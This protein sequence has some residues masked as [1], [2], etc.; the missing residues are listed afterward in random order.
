MKRIAFAFA[1]TALL[2]FPLGAQETQREKKD[3]NP[4]R[5]LVVAC[6]GPF[7][8]RATHAEMV[9]TF[10]AANVTYGDVPGPEGS[11]EQATILFADDP[12]KRV[13]IQWHDAKKRARPLA[14]TIGNAEAN[15]QWT[16]PYGVKLGTG[17]AE[18]QKI[19]GK[20]FEVSGFEW[21]LGGFANLQNTKFEKVSGGCTLSLR[22]AP[23]KAIPEAKQYKKLIGDTKI[24]SD[25]KLLREINPRV[26]FMTIGYGE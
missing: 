25:D 4:A 7:A 3:Y 26:Q 8:K 1:A 6:R 18:I 15:S 19:A 21:D 23:E 2:A 20:R 11:T 5:D 13:E 16:G 17:V 14:I 24:R 10:G 9:K 12:A 22:F